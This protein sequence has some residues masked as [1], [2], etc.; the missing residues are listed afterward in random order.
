MTYAEREAIFSKDYLTIKDV[1][2]LVGT[3]YQ[4]AARLMRQSKF[5]TDRLKVRGKLHVEDYFE[6]YHIT[7]RQRYLKQEVKD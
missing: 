1:A 3:T 4:V 2:A 7:D 5:K 6:Y